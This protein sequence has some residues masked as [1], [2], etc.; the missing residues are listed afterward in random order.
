MM[1]FNKNSNEQPNSQNLPQQ[2]PQNPQQ[3][4]NNP[5]NFMGNMQNNPLMNFGMSGPQ[6]NPSF[7]SEPFNYGSMGQVLIKIK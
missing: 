3:N 1:G 6:M 7:E 5:Q 4:Q 2:N